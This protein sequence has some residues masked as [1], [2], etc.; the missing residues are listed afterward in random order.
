MRATSCGGVERGRWPGNP[1]SRTS[2]S[3]RE[4]SSWGPYRRG[5]RLCGVLPEFVVSQS[6][7]SRGPRWKKRCK[8]LHTFS[9]HWE[10]G[11]GETWEEASRQRAELGL[12]GQQW[13]DADTYP[14][15]QFISKLHGMFP[16]VLQTGMKKEKEAGLL[17][18]A[19]R[20]RIK[21]DCYPSHQLQ[22]PRPRQQLGVLPRD[23]RWGRDFLPAILR[24]LR[25][26]HWL[27]ADD[28]A[29][30][31][32]GQVLFMELAR[33]LESHAGRHLP[34]TQHSRFTGSEMSLQEKGRVLRLAVTLLGRAGGRESIL[35]AAITT[36]CRALVPLGVGMVVGVKGR[37]LFTRPAEVWHHLQKLRQ[38]NSERCARQQQQRVARR[39]HKQRCAQGKLAASPGDSLGQRERCPGKGG[40]KKT[41]GAYAGDFYAGPVIPHG[42]RR[43][44]QYQVV[45]P[46]DDPVSKV[47]ATLFSPPQRCDKARRPEQ[48]PRLSWLWVCAAH[49]HTQ[50]ATC[51]AVGRGVRHC[52]ARGH[53]GHPR[54]S[55]QERSRGAALTRTS[56]ARTPGRGGGGGGA[57]NRCKAR[58]QPALRGP[59]ERAMKRVLEGP[60]PPPHASGRAEECS[61]WPATGVRV[62][63]SPNRPPLEVLT[64]ARP[65]VANLPGTRRV[66]NQAARTAS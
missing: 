35:P 33:D 40:A 31:G 20:K 12:A 10:P 52:C 29:P 27:P 14:L 23:W 60:P 62:W 53:V 41:A 28:D 5:L 17:F 38:Y 26:L 63:R 45:E 3:W 66:G 9:R 47:G 56:G 44:P 55:A 57:A 19:E 4:R 46:E 13:A 48:H 16:A 58:A 8:E 11:P 6:G 24:C 43:G 59:R 34:P 49:R 50:R 7:L 25:E 21:H 51:A 64:Q 37:P 54:P 39:Q 22:L 42:A 36:R 15:E 18:P 61:Q 32:H 2:C 1:S 65:S 30:V